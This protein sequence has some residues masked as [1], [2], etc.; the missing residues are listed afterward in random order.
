[1]SNERDGATRNGGV[2]GGIKAATMAAV[3]APQ[4]EHDWAV[5][6]KV[7]A[8]VGIPTLGAITVFAFW[9]GQV[10]AHV[11]RVDHQTTVNAQQ[12]AD[13]LKIVGGTVTVEAQ[14]TEAIENEKE[15]RRTQQV[16]LDRLRTQ[17]E[18]LIERG[19]HLQ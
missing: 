8:F 14:H 18:R 7:V 2:L 15:A 10:S 12:I 6:G 16:E 13:Q 9:L 17:I 3:D 1:M 4:R 11:D 5:L 19:S